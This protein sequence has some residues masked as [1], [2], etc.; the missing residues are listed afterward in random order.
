MTNLVHIKAVNRYRDQFNPLRGLTIRRAIDMLEAGDRGEYADLQ[1]TYRLIEK[2]DA[3]LKGLLERYD[4][5][6]LKLEW[7]ISTVD[8]KELP[9]GATRE[10]ADAQAQRLREVY[11]GI[12]NLNKAFEFLILAEFRGYAHLEK[13]RT[14]AGELLK[15][16]P[17]DQWHW[18]R[19][20][21]NGEW[22]YNKDAKSG[23]RQGE[24]IED[25]EDRFLIYEVARPVNEIALLNYVF[26]NLCK[27]DWVGFVEA[28]GIT[29]TFIVGPP[30]VPA[31]KE[32]DYQKL[33][34]RMTSNAR[35][36]M[37]NGS[38][39][40][41]VEAGARGVNPHKE[42]KDDLTE[43]LVLAGT[44]GK[45]TMLAESGSGTLAGEAHQDAWDEILAGKAK[46]I[47]EL[48]QC[49]IDQ[50]EVL[51]KEFA[52]QPVLAYFE[53][54]LEGEDDDDKAFKRDVWKAFMAD[55]TV[56][57]IL[58]NLTDLQDLTK[59]VGLP[60]NQE[61]KDP[62]VPVVDEQ[63]KSLSGDVTRDAQGDIV[64][65]TPSDVQSPTTKIYGPAM[66]LKDG[67]GDLAITN[68]ATA[69]KA[70]TALVAKAVAADLQPLRTRLARILE[71]QDG[72]ILANRLKDFLG[73]IDALGQDI[74][75]D[76]E[77]ARALAAIQASAIV[78]GF[79]AGAADREGSD[80]LLMNTAANDGRW[81]TIGGA[82]VLV[83][84][85]QTPREA[86]Q[87]HA[88]GDGKKKATRKISIVQAAQMLHERGW[89]LGKPHDWVPGSKDIN[90]TIKHKDG[91][92][93][94]MSGR[95]IV[96]FLNS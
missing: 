2:R 66:P 90:Y 28:F 27:K 95:E 46:K 78:D 17:V 62:Y 14:I 24:V 18:V 38:D 70:A 23:T 68:R 30:N 3:T 32:K 50:K 72:D 77:T 13:H 73:E 96:K 34:E 64:G 83:K 80:E 88:A 55:G 7:K 11:T 35:G 63:G 49:E 57:D 4:G 65:A 15:L 20:G 12:K 51:E 79:E 61:Y 25:L 52:G 29:P 33:A 89:T 60:V 45:L 71:I 22:Q 19:D 69:S 92:E 6:L 1:W 56:V 47:S 82:H 40:K 36:Y 26:K 58:A 39:V 93:K 21:I 85:G 76:P 5:G 59:N 8:E 37:P 41:T 31:D 16:E 67:T 87:E 42:L 81:I 94:T 54:S 74:A 86:L 44:G 48:L 84:D 43:E 9:P 75:A 10:M 53:L 91:R